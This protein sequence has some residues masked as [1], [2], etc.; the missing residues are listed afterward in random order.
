MSRIAL[1]ST[2]TL[3]ENTTPN[4]D[5]GEIGVFKKFSMEMQAKKASC[6]EHL[7]ANPC[8]K[9]SLATCCLLSSAACCA[10]SLIPWLS[11]CVDMPPVLA[12]LAT[13][14]GSKSTAASLSFVFGAIPANCMCN[15]SCHLFGSRNTPAVVGVEPTT[16]SNVAYG[17]VV[18]SSQIM[19]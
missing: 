4:V 6:T 2:D 19:S 7:D 15:V 10:S 8:E 13:I 11:I 17:T 1:D 18:P 5:A 16:T 9:Y 14:G 12:P 3:L